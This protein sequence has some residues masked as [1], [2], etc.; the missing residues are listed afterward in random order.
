MKRTA[1]CILA[2]TIVTINLN[3]QV[4]KTTVKTTVKTIVSASPLKTPIDSFSYAAGINIAESM[5]QQGITNLNSAMVKRAIDD[6]MNKRKTLLSEEQCNATLQHQ[7][8]AFAQKKSGAETA[9][10]K[11]FL[12]ANKKRPGVITLPD[13]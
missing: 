3:A 4:K 12:E 7:L 1:L 13:G 11:A 2:I 10:G 8:Q 5:K 6:V 9:K